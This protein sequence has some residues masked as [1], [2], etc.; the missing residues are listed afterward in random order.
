MH[1]GVKPVWFQGGLPDGPR[2]GKRFDA[3]T[4]WWSHEL[5]HRETLRNYP[6]RLAAYARDRDDLESEFLSGAPVAEDR[7]AFTA[8]C[9][10]RAADAEEK[11]L[12]DVRGTP[13]ARRSAL[14]RRAWRTWDDL[15][16]LP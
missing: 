13:E 15:A 8:E 2:A 3:S 9:F 5:L 16:G 10:T 7:A 14:Y 12:V 6:Q 4:L 1:V 11:W